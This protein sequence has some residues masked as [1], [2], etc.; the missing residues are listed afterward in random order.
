MAILGLC[1]NMERLTIVY[2][3]KFSY[4]F[5]KYMSMNF[6]KLKYLN[7]RSCPIQEDLDFLSKACPN[8]EEINLSGDSWV[9]SECIAGLAKHPK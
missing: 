5:P 4:D 3:R 1:D 6:Y 7:L 8:L 2:T 9:K